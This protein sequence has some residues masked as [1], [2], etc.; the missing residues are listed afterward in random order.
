MKLSRV[1]LK[2]AVFASSAAATASAEP[3]HLPRGFHEGRC[4]YVVNGK[5]RI[6]GPC[7]YKINKGGGFSIDG[8][9]QTYGGKDTVDRGASALTY[10]RDWWAEVYWQDGA[11]LAYGNERIPDVHGGVLWALRRHGAC[12]L[13]ERVEICLWKK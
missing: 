8:P 10:S 5:R 1:I 4:L 9:R 2:V 11:W 7:Y 3:S 13:G 6:D 12:F